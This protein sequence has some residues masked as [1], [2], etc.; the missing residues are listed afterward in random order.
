MTDD[1]I[2][3]L[4]EEATVDCYD[5]EECLVGFFT[6]IE[7]ELQLP[8]KAKVFEEEIEVIS[9]KHI[10]N[11]IKVICQ[12]NDSKQSVDITDIAC[13]WNKIE[14]GKWVIAYKSWLT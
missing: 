12:K 5:E 4:I 7:D 9:V 10:R 3:E 6:M 11:S 14:G 8:F 13:D 1:Q 2:E